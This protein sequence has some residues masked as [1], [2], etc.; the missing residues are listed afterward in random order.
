MN[1]DFDSINNW[2][3]VYFVQAINGGPIKIGSAHNVERRLR[4]LQT[5]NPIDLVILHKTSG[6]HN[7]ETFLHKEFK[8]ININGEW[9]RNTDKLLSYINDLKIED[10]MC[11]RIYSIVEY[12]ESNGY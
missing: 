7:L 2:S 4:I 1:C 11:G 6:G 10:Q 3:Y 5:G 9:F 8:D 12:A